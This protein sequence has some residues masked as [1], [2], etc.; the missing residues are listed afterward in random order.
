MLYKKVPFILPTVAIL[1]TIIKDAKSVKNKSCPIM[2]TLQ[3][4]KNISEKCMSQI[5]NFENCKIINML[6]KQKIINSMWY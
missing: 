3:N 5:C 6:W 2:R 4:H 1:S